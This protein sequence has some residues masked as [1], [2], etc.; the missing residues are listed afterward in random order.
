MPPRIGKKT[1]KPILIID[2]ETGVIFGRLSAS[3]RNQGRGA[4]FRIQDVWIASQ[5]IQHGCQVLTKNAK[6]FE[7]IPGLSLQII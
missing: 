7:D 2:E 6:D 3:L 4:D 5:A 1:A